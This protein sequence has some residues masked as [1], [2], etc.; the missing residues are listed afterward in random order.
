MR[1]KRKEPKSRLEHWIAFTVQ[2]VKCLLRLFA[3]A[4]IFPT[5]MMAR[6]I[7]PPTLPRA[8][9]NS[10]KTEGEKEGKRR[11]APAAADGL[12]RRLAL[13]KL[14]A[15]HEASIEGG[16][17]AGWAGGGALPAGVRALAL[18]RGVRG[19]TGWGCNPEQEGI[20]SAFD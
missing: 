7:P 2:L 16:T 9:S 1:R 4:R 18:G 8:T 14:Q 13:G 20:E 12:R 15:H 3:V 17:M 10:S 11:K 6:K 5:R 19:T